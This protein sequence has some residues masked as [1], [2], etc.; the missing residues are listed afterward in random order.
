MA[1]KSARD[2]FWPF[3]DFLP[4]ALAA[5]PRS[6]K[7]S[8]DFFFRGSPRPG[9]ARSAAK[10]DLVSLAS[11]SAWRDERKA[12]DRGGGT[13][14]RSV[15]APGR[16]RSSARGVGDGEGEGRRRGASRWRDAANARRVGT[17]GV[18]GRRRGWARLGSAA[19]VRRNPRRASP[20]RW[21]ARAARGSRDGARVHRRDAIDASR[22]SLSR[23]PRDAS[24][25]LASAFAR[26]VAAISP[27]GDAREGA[28]AG[29][30]AERLVLIFWRRRGGR[31]R[32]KGDG[33]GAHLVGPG[34][35]GA[36]CG[37]AGSGVSVR[38]MRREGSVGGRADVLER[39]TL[40]TAFSTHICG[41][42][43]PVLRGSA[44]RGSRFNDLHTP[45][46]SNTHRLVSHTKKIFIRFQRVITLRKMSESISSG[47]R[48]RA[49]SLFCCLA[50]R[51][52]GGRARRARAAVIC[53][54][55]RCR[56]SIERVTPPPLH[57]NPIGSLP[58]RGSRE[59]RVQRRL[60][61]RRLRTPRRPPRASSRPSSSLL[62]APLPRRPPVPAS[63]RLR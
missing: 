49:R 7:S 62:S 26:D 21:R 12:G 10:D 30:D 54:P 45:P 43:G 3:L 59:S 56:C 6:G 18:A 17:R 63:Q 36:P 24:R 29:H 15:A 9:K 38:S 16:R 34:S 25:A 44:S 57:P 4:G 52:R 37:H 13:G 2:I 32:G 60:R 48:T 28:A 23:N 46:I 42:L 5:A 40:A 22:A 33:R 20:S 35:R 61:M 19:R 31:A 11:S 41:R 39:D 47:C 55:P 8:S 58:V 27:A 14:S 1:S 50:G 53:T 51:R